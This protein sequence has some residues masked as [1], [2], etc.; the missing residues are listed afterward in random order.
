MN[1]EELEKSLIYQHVVKCSVCGHIYSANG[2]HSVDPNTDT[3]KHYADK[4]TDN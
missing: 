1:I 4:I 3:C 2:Q